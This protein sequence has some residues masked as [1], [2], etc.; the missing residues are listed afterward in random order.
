MSDHRLAEVYGR[1]AAGYAASLDPT[2]RPLADR[3]LREAG[4]SPGQSVLD[5]A[6]GTGVIARAAADL[7]TWPLG[8]DLAAGML[9]VARR[10][11]PE[12]IPYVAADAS[13]LPL[14]GGTFDIV[15][16]GLALS[17]IADIQA[18]LAEILRVLRG[19]GVLVASA[20]AMAGSNPAFSTVLDVLRRHASGP[21]HPF[22][23]LIDERTWSDA[24]SGCEIL[25]GAGFEPTRVVIDRVRGAYASAE[26]A[27]RWTMAWPS[28]AQTLGELAE[29]ARAAV[30]AQALDALARHRALAWELAFNCFV[31]VKPAG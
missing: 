23:E 22:A 14:R 29:D 17:H 11:T 25:S 26:D 30:R 27:F 9:A 5:L 28:Y 8:V 1:H 7:G 2:L 16:C 13:A 6:T 4:A 21:V 10:L 24:R 15:T 31:A 3:M 18:V 12:T 20:W 19:G